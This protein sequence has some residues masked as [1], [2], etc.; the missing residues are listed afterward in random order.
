MSKVEWIDIC[1]LLELGVYNFRISS[2]KVVPEMNI[3]L[4]VFFVLCL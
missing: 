2:F 3:T 1:D 4:V